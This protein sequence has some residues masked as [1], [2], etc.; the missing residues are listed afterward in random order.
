MRLVSLVSLLL[1]ASLIAGAKDRPWQDAK[2]TKVEVSEMQV[3]NEQFRS[4]A[5]SGQAG[6]PLSSGGDT[7]TVKTYTYRFQAEGKNYAGTV[8]K[9]PLEGVKEGDTVKVFSQRGFL[10]VLPPDGKERKLNS[11][12]AD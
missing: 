2:L 12:K 7:R 10:Y 9:K 11:I 6:V 4:S 1:F 3:Q 8:D 5:P